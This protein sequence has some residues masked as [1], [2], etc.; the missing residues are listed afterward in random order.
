MIHD[1]GITTPRPAVVWFAEQMERQLQKN[2]HKGG[3]D[4][5][6]LDY[7]FE[8]MAEERVELEKAVKKLSYP[9]R[10][11]VD[12]AN[13]IREAADVSNFS[14]MIADVIAT[15]YGVGPK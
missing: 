11:L 9:D 3:W 7:L 14:M 2:D 13:V 1:D 6:T 8:R 4:G 12:V 5:C 10:S 15:R